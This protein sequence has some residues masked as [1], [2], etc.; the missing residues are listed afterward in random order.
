V[1]QVTFDACR[2]DEPVHTSDTTTLAL[3]GREIHVYHVN[4]S[5][6]FGVPRFLFLEPEIHKKVDVILSN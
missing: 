1:V 3:A 2:N 6:I 5:F 4:A